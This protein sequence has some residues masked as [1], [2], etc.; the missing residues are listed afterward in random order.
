MTFADQI[1]Y[2]RMFQHV[3]QKG[4]E[5]SINS[6]KIFQNAK[7]LEVSVGNSYLRIS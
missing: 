1:R 7:A 4:G 5:S 2:N 3:V 6:I